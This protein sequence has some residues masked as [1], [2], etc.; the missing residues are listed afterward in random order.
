MKK[1]ILICTFIFFL[2]NQIFAQESDQKNYEVTG[3][4]SIMNGSI[5]EYVFSPYCMNVDDVESRLDWDISNIPLFSCSVNYSN[6]S[7]FLSLKSDFSFL[8][9]S[10]NM[11]DYDWL[12]F[13][14]YPS[15]DP[16]EI[17]NYSIHSNTLSSYMNF[18]IIAGKNLSNSKHFNFI[19][20]IEFDFGY[21]NMDGTD[22]YRTYKSEG[23]MQYDLDGKIISYEQYSYLFFFGTRMDF[24]FSP[25]F[26]I[27][28]SGAI[29]PFLSYINSFDYHWVNKTIGGTIFNDVFLSDFV[30]KGSAGCSYII[31]SN[32]KISIDSSVT[33]IPICKGV[34]YV[35]SLDSDGNIISNTYH[36]SLSSTSRTNRFLW[37]AGISFSYLF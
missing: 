18:S 32:L 34:T 24:T 1:S 20:F 12:N 6:D 14:S 36:K 23:W 30:I 11:Q 5:S 31:N 27:N 26:S 17:T 13:Q 22:G 28:F 2:F 37:N 35:N 33:Y 25:S 29:S 16:T 3:S 7:L 9:S 19:P 21:F 10:G 4:F 15:D 8:S